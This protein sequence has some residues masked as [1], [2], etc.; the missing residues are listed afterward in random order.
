MK[1][2]LIISSSPRIDGNSSLLCQ[3]FCKGAKSVGHNVEVVNLTQ[4][5][6]GYCI[7]CYACARTGECFQNDDMNALAKKMVEADVIVLAS[8]VYFYSMAGQLKVFIDRMV[9]NYTK[10]KADIYI[11]VTAWDSNT[12]NLHSTIEAIRGFSRDC[13]EDCQEKG[14]IMAGG[15]NDRGDIV[16]KKEM[17]TAYNYGKNC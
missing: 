1:N 7:G 14:I 11:F 15:V 6:I 4:L 16:G 3:E 12:K 10:V 13:L 17:L 2:V 5:N 9:Q 8:P